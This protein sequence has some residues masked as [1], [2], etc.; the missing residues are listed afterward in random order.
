MRH[1]A[2]D[3]GGPTWASAPRATVLRPCRDHPSSNGVPFWQITATRGSHCEAGQMMS[4]ARGLYPQGAL[5]HYEGGAQARPLKARR[6]ACTP[7]ESWEP[8]RASRHDFPRPREDVL[9]PPVVVAPPRGPPP[10]YSLH[11]PFYGMR[12]SEQ[13]LGHP[14]GRPPP[15]HAVWPLRGG[16]WPPQAGPYRLH[17]ARMPPISRGALLTRPLGLFIPSTVMDEFQHRSDRKPVPR[18]AP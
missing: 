3:P 12:C 8:R 9:N 6:W 17:R 4:G 11:G 16:Q 7:P 10:H 14:N 13:A 1:P 2:D 18:H 15:T 5:F